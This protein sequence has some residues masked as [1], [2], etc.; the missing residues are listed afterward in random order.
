[1]VEASLPGTTTLDVSAG[2]RTRRSQS[3]PG[4][5]TREDD[6]FIRRQPL[7]HIRERCRVVRAPPPVA[8]QPTSQPLCRPTDIIHGHH[9]TAEFERAGP[10][11]S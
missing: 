4:I 9:H 2:H 8:P 3:L 7:Q 11:V 10:Y 1:M 6:H 5:E